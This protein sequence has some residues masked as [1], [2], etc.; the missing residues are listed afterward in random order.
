MLR[1]AFISLAVLASVL[2]ATQAVAL[3]KTP[4]IVID[5]KGVVRE[6]YGV[7][8]D[9]TLKQ[10]PRLRFKYRLREEVGDEEITHTTATI[11]ARKGVKVTAWFSSS[12]RLYRFE[13]STP[14]A[15]G[16]RGLKV[17]STLA[18]LKK[19]FP[20]RRPYWGRTPHDEYHAG[21]GGIRFGYGFSPFDLPKEAWSHD[22]KQYELDPSIKVTKIAIEPINPFADD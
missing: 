18:D 19:V 1:L 16:E 14:G 11:I 13:T 9:L 20:D 5:D 22:P 10:L 12:G 7:P 17:G 15:L 3:P 2:P 21:F 8:L 6:Y 4:D